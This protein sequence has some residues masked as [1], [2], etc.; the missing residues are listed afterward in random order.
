MTK[1]NKDTAR[2]KFRKTCGIKDIQAQH[3][4]DPNYEYAWKDASTH[5]GLRKIDRFIDA[6]WEV[7]YSTEKVKDDRSTAS[8]QD[9]KDNDLRQSPLMV[10]TRSGHNMFR[11]RILKTLREENAKAAKLKR[12]AELKRKQKIVSD[13]YNIHMTGSEVDPNKLTKE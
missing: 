5:E 6:G 9:G 13:G 4:E 10:T 11:M 3:V 12:M 1:I 2:E 7:V 8:N